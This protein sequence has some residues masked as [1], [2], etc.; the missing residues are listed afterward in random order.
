M[1]HSLVIGSTI[2]TKDKSGNSINGILLN[3]LENTVII[4]CT[5]SSRILVSKQ[6]LET[7]GYVFAVTPSKIPFKI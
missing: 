4:E 1:V 6:L 7:N 2:N 5:D 3:V